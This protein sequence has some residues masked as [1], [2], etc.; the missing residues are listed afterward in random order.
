[1]SNQPSIPTL[2]RVFNND[3]NPQY[4]IEFTFGTSNRRHGI[5]V[6]KLRGK[7]DLVEKLVLLA[8]NIAHDKDLK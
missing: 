6:D 5:T 3:E 1:M 2:I 8:Q 7:E 4:S